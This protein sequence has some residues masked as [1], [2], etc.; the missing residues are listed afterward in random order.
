GRNL[1]I[2][3]FL[4]S[5]EKKFNLDGPDGFQHYWHD[6]E[7]PPEMFSTR[8]SG[9]GSIMIWGAFSFSG[10]LEL[11]VVQ[12]RQTV[13]GYVQM[14]QRASLM[15]EGLRLCGNSWDFFRENNITLLDHPT[16]GLILLNLNVSISSCGGSSA[17]VQSCH[18]FGFE[19]SSVSQVLLWYL[20]TVCQSQS[21]N[22]VQT[23]LDPT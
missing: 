2:F 9:G 7:I 11:Q 22:T 1:Q 3:T 17:A 10:T 14:L 15:T 23:D 4:F 21:T 13:A 5:D 16:F 19:P 20:D 8:H 6:K 12:G 18:R